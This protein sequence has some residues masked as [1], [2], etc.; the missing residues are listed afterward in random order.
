LKKDT[1]KKALAAL[2][3][4]GLLAGISLSATGCRWIGKSA[5]SSC[6]GKTTEQPKTSCGAGSCTAGSCTG[7]TGSTTTPGT[8]GQ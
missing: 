3:V 4:A 1:V 6:S 8:A 7:G 2:S 5:C